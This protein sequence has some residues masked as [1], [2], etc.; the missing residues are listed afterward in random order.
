MNLVPSMQE[1]V[2]TDLLVPFPSALALR[3]ISGKELLPKKYYI[4]RF[5]IG[6]TKAQSQKIELEVDADTITLEFNGD[7][8][9]S[10][11]VES[12]K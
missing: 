6:A 11:E 2:L 10:I 8:I 5:S 4:E 7:S 3:R 12:F 9:A 1:L